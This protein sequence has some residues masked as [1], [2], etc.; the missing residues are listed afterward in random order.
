MNE[1]FASTV[2]AWIWT[3][4]PCCWHHVRAMLPQDR[5]SVATKRVFSRVACRKVP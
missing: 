4:L 3:R 5:Q 2:W 1:V